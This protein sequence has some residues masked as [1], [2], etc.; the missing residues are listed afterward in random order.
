[1]PRETPPPPHDDDDPAWPE[2]LPEG[3]EDLDLGDDK[4][5]APGF[6]PMPQAS[7]EEEAVRHRITKERARQLDD[8][9]RSR[10][11]GLS[12]IGMDFVIAVVV[13]GGL[14][15]L[16]DYWLKTKPWLLLVGIVLGLIGGSYRFAKAA[17]AANREFG[18]PKK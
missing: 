2:D 15:W 1:M 14:G 18:Q 12:G 6:P 7:A 4:I 16:G 8:E 5:D 3:L 10:L 13:M 17:L 9:V 11:V